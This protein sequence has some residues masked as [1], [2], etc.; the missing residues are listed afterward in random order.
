[1]PGDILKVAL[2]VLVYGKIHSRIK[3]ILY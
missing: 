2:A 3:T 1:V